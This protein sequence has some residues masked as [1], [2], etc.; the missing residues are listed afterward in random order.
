MNK[1]V[2]ISPP[3]T[4]SNKIVVDVKVLTKVMG[5]AGEYSGVF[6]FTI[7]PPV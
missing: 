1:P 4:G 5:P 2:A 7:A 3:A 6:T